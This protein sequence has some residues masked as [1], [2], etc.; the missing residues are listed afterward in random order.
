MISSTKTVIALGEILWDILPSE[1]LLGGA[2]ANFCH[3]LRQLGIDARMVSRVGTD[4]L[5]DELLAGLATLDF[6]LSLVQRDPAHPTGTV[7]VTLSSDGDPTFTINNGV[8][9]DYLEPTRDLMSAA[10]S[11]SLI[12]FG[13][14]VQRS[15]QTRTTLYAILD[16]AQQA[17]KLL[18][19]N[20]RRNC[21]SSD[22][23]RES[24]KRADILKLNIAE[25]GILSEM[26]GIPERTPEG[27]SARI[28]EHFQI[29]TVLVTLGARGVYARRV[30]GESCTVP[31]VAITVVD[32]IGSGD[33]FTAGF[34]CKRLLS[35]PLEECCHFGNLIGALNATKKGGMPD[36]SPAEV[37]E[38]VAHH[39]A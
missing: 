30:N 19:I 11:A 7:N 8:A 27:F 33:S 17:I 39:S 18:D 20:L 25:V 38:F 15:E 32:T 10:A 2:P 12:C 5:G 36:I 4:L 22:T 37:T 35:A 6:D 31:G 28:I 13:T 24:L 21:Y 14:L 1:K 3:R 34:V 29:D 9:Y 26:L 23:V 16:A